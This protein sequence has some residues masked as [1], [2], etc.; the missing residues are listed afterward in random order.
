VL[1]DSHD[2]V[3]SLALVHQNLYRAG[4]FVG[5]PLAKQVESLCAQLLR[6][7]GD[8]Q[9]IQLDTRVAD[10]SLELDKA[11]PF[12]LIINELVN[13]ALKHAFPEGRAGRVSVEL[14]P[15]IQGRYALKVSDD[16]VGLPADFD[17]RRHGSLG[18]QLVTDL[19]HQLHGTVAV[20]GSG[21][22]TFTISFVADPSG[23]QP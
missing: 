3:R 1:A 11:V 13:N 6:S 16:G 21:G 22:T 5:V 19:A 10:A 2:R 15:P 9:R 23:G 20:E 7:Y 18:L 17:L 14:H 8:G 4:K 12:V